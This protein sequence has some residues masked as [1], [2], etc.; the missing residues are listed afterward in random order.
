MN[1]EALIEE[2]K[3]V[4]NTILALSVQDKILTMRIKEETLKLPMIYG[5][6]IKQLKCTHYSKHDNYYPPESTVINPG[7]VI[8][9]FR[10]PTIELIDQK[11]HQKTFYL[12]D[13]NWF[14]IPFSKEY[15]QFFLQD[16]L[17]PNQKVRFPDLKC[18]V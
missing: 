7:D 16:M 9:F 18:S 10:Y 3:S 8:K 17:G 15:F 14:N 11:N 6:C 5:R 1:I 13:G 4:K 2:Q 12:R